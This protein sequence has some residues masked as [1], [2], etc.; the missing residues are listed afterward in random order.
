MALRRLDKK[1]VWTMA[2][3]LYWFFYLPFTAVIIL[4]ILF[5]P[6][7]VEKI[8][9]ETHNLDQAII[10][11]RAF[12]KVARQDINTGR[13]YIGQLPENIEEKDLIFDNSQSPKDL[14]IKISVDGKEAY[15]NKEFYADAKP[16]A[17]VRYR[18]YKQ[19]KPAIQGNEIKAVEVEEV[20]PKKY[21]FS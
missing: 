21:E 18:S 4:V 3:M 10:A 8:Q 12:A 19:V 14:A 9:L 13:I 11:E 1:A 20:F 7:N 6:Q 2:D 17:P 16:L 5:I 15:Y